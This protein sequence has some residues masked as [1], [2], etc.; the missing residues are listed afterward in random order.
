[1]CGISGILSIND[2]PINREHLEKLHQA[3]EHRG[4]DSE[5]YYYDEHIGL[6][7]RRL[8]IIDLRR[9]SDQPF[10]VD[11]RYVLIYN[12]EIYNYIEIKKELIKLG[13]LFKTESDTEVLLK[14]YIQWG[15]DCQEKFN[16]MWAFAIW[17][18]EYKELFCSRDRYGIKPF[19][20]SIYSDC[21]YF[22][23]EIK[24]LRIDKLGSK[25]NYE[26]LS[27]F[28]YSGCTNSTNNTFFKDINSLEAGHSLKINRKGEKY[29]K[30]WYDLNKKINIDEN[31]FK[32]DE[33]LYHINN[34]IRIRMR[35][36]VS[37]GTAL[38]G[39]LDSS[40]I[41]TLASNLYSRKNKDKLFGIHAKSTEEDT[42][43]SYYA[44]IA[45]KHAGCS[46]INV[47]P[48]YEYFKKI[49]NE[50]I[51]FQDEPFASTSSIMQFNVMSKARAL[52]LKVMLDGQGSDEILLGYTRLILPRLITTYRKNGILGFLN[53][54]KNSNNN[55]NDINYKS[56]IKY[57]IGGGSSK[58]RTSYLRNRLN[59]VNLSI[60]PTYNLYEELKNQRGHIVN[61]Q[62]IELK[63]TS[64]PQILRSEDRNSMAN[65][66][67]ARVPFLD[68]KLVEYCLNLKSD[69]KVKN[70]WTKYPIRSI[71][72]LPS[73]IAWRKSK[74][75]YDSPEKAWDKKF[76]RE[77]L[78]TI[79]NSPLILEIT[80]IKELEEKWN[81]LN[82]KERWRL[83]NVAIW[84]KIFKVI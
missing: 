80:N 54:I 49:I 68:Y 31:E 35:S 84:Q 82:S 79:R 61:S 77:M 7:H 22:G 10:N 43:E 11:E 64:L 40:L 28:L 14:A 72:K 12:G 48:S 2:K 74:L 47:T 73:E 50:I 15:E 60:D 71:N 51:F 4:P 65:S 45:A 76:S 30:C 55:N 63:K 70:G 23:S 53:E 38:S 19:Y 6:A 27:I 44:E 67:E 13:H 57:L 46:L 1:M 36:D 69:S 21:F 17:D 16:G 8:S 34:A 33:F 18:R 41:V 20:W 9:E 62:I 52:G 3:I 83:Y 24:Q 59:F 29:I 26:E 81:V 66:V 75:G 32:P 39:G 37:L 56:L 25:V 5:G 78:S 58:L 42:N